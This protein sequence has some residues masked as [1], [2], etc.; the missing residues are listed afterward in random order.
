MRIEYSEKGNYLFPNLALK[1]Q[2]DLEIGRYGM[3]R[4]RFLMEN[5]SGQYQALLLTER[6]EE[7]LAETERMAKE[8]QE[9]LMKALQKQYP[10]P[11]KITDLMGWVSHMNGLKAMAEEIVAREIIYA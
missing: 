8:S 6:L 7:H 10:A 3:M 4:K 11:D 9:E 2:E 1:T 5:R